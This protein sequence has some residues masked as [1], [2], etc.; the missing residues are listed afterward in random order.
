MSKNK[1]TGQVIKT[2]TLKQKVQHHYTK[3]D[4]GTS[5]IDK[6]QYNSS[7]CFL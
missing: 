6:E 1:K 3:Q 4:D 5:T 7:F 2:L